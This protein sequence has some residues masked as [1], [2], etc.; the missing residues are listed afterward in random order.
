MRF[1]IRHVQQ[2]FADLVEAR[3]IALDWMNDPAPLGTTPV[4]VRELEPDGVSPI[5]G[6][7]VAFTVPEEYS[8]EEFELG[9]LVTVE[10]PLYIDVYGAK[11]AVAVSLAS[12]I[13]DYLSGRVVDVLDHTQDPP[14][15]SGVQAEVA[16]CALYRPEQS[17]GAT[18]FK[19]NWRE[20]RTML[21]VIYLPEAS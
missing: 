18:D 2:T 10:M 13:K 11:P 21:N 1:R 3:L 7:V 16:T 17:Y 20:V 14:V 9:G 6:N 8:E 4:D 19:R 5:S 15:V 12:D